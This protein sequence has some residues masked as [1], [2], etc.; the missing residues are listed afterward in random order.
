MIGFDR[1]KFA[2]NMFGGLLGFILLVA[3]LMILFPNIDDQTGESIIYL[4]GIL[5]SGFWLWVHY[6]RLRNLNQSG[7]LVILA[8]I[9]VVGVGL[10]L[11]LLFAPP[12]E[13]A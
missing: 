9:P 12:P 4:F 10:F 2:V 13:T 6:Q 7:W 3:A 1:K 5:L 8:F 11:Y